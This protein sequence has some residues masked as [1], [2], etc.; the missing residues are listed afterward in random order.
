M[1]QPK[2]VTERKLTD[3]TG[4]TKDQIKVRRKLWVEN[5]QYKWGADGILWYNI[6]EIDK[7][8]D[9]GKAA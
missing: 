5:R 4:L 2:W 1:N 9:Q 3:L 8:V 7:W 6:E